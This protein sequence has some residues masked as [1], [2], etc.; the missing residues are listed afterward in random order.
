MRNI[1]VID[2]EGDTNQICEC[3]KDAM[4]VLGIS[5]DQNPHHLCEE[6]LG[7]IAKR[8]IDALV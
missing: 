6:C 7:E 2:P 3:G 5:S 8:I 1:F 4:F